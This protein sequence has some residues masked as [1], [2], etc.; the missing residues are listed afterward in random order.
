MQESSTLLDLDTM[1]HDILL[2]ASVIALI[3]LLS[4]IHEK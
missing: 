4:L 3:T 2:A 1:I